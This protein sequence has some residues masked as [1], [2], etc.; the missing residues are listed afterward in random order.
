MGE[1]AVKAARAVGYRGAGTVEFLLDAHRNFYFLEMNTRLQVEHPV[2]ELCTGLDLVRMQ[3]EVAQGERIIAQ[4]EVVRRGHAIEARVYAEDPARNFLPSPGRISYL[5]APSGPG[6]RDDGGVYGGW[7]VSQ[8]YDPMISKVCAWAPSREQAIARLHRALGEYTVHGIA[9]NLRYLRAVLE[10][11]AFRS[12]DYDTGFCTLHAKEL[13]PPSDPRYE[14][15]ALI[16]AAVAAHRR[17]RDEAAAFAARS[18]DPRAR[19]SWRSLG[20]ARE[21]DGGRT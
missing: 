12:G 4:E 8:F 21:L 5:R 17:D 3:L 20:R 11:P 6:I 10:H 7:V 15:L 14:E 16:A 2:T 13:V 18:G 19:S 9:V 1:V